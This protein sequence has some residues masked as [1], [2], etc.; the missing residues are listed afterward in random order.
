M[1]SGN[2]TEVLSLDDRVKL[3]IL[4]SGVPEWPSFYASKQS[5]AA[6]KHLFFHRVS[7]SH[8]LRFNATVELLKKGKRV[9]ST[10]LAGIGKS[11]ELNAYFM[12]FLPHI[13][14]EGWPPEVWYRFNSKLLIFKLDAE[15]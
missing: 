14:E 6:D 5:D 1:S 11:T 2:I 3:F 8:A 7:S 13:G 12:A 15:T 9:V 10:G 4:P